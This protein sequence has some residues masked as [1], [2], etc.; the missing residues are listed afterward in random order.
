[1]VD[2]SG[3]S[4][5]W[6]NREAIQ[7]GYFKNSEWG[8]VPA[9]DRELK[10]GYESRFL[11]KGDNVSR[12][13]ALAIWTNSY[14]DL[15]NDYEAERD[16]YNYGIYY[17]GANNSG[18][19]RSSGM[20]SDIMAA[21]EQD[22]IRA[23]NEVKR[24]RKQ[25]AQAIAD[26]TSKLTAQ[27]DQ[28]L[29]DLTLGF[30][31][32]YS[33]LEAA[34]TNQTTAYNEYQTVMEGQLQASQAAYDGQ[35]TMNNNLQVAYTPP[36]NPNGVAASAGRQAASLRR[37]KNNRLSELSS[38]SIVSGLGTESNPLSGLQLA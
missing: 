4:S 29:S 25:Q 2:P 16:K 24:L 20:S 5:W 32:R 17:V 9:E 22:R 8:G 14:N 18:S 38:L 6:D 34:L 28:Q 10:D 19:N 7:S 36:S 1:M 23:E 21:L 30:D 31:Q 26:N 33:A 15:R 11:G 3:F 27:Y 37:Q 35:V 12:N 13:G